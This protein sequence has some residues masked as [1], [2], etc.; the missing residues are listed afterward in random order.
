MILRTMTAAELID[1]RCCCIAFNELFTENES[2]II[3]GF[4]RNPFYHTISTLY[5]TVSTPGPLQFECLKQ[6]AR[7]CDIVEAWQ[8]PLE[9]MTQE[10]VSSRARE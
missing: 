5:D 6:I 3:R 9:N 1:L 8:P 7:R 10:K 4:L 2:V